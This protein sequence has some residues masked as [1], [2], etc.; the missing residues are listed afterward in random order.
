MIL[1]AS[2]T[3][4]SPSSVKKTVETNFEQLAK[5]YPNKSNTVCI[6]TDIQMER[7]N[8][9]LRSSIKA[10]RENQ[11]DAKNNRYPYCIVWTPLPLITWFLPFIGKHYDVKI[12][13]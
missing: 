7:M 8:S 11:I 13:S 5:N 12:F 9:E 6:D 10:S 2:S 3:N 1:A 4:S